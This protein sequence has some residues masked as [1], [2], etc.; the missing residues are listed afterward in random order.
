FGD[1]QV[2]T[3]GDLIYIGLD[4]R[5]PAN[6]TGIYSLKNQLDI[7]LIAA[8]GQVSAPVQ[9]ALIDQCEELRYRF[10]VLD[11]QGPADDTID[12]VQAQRQSFDTKYAAFYH[13]WLTIPDPF[14]PNLSSISQ[15]PIPPS[16]HVLG[17]Y[18]RVDD[19]RG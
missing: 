5:E 7:S 1:D 16:G 9:Q 13:P 15:F 8:P 19:Q 18:A 6:R 17:I 11:A 14:P 3:M 10:A 12:D 2:P 4:D